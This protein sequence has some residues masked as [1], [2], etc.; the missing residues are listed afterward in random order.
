V[1]SGRE[2]Y[3]G[4]WRRSGGHIGSVKVRCKSAWLLHFA[5]ALPIRWSWQLDN[6]TALIGCRGY[7][8]AGAGAVV[9][10][11]RWCWIVRPCAFGCA[12]MELVVFP[13]GPTPPPIRDRANQVSG[14]RGVRPVFAYVHHPALLQEWLPCPAA[15][16]GLDTRRRRTTTARRRDDG[17]PR[18][19]PRSLVIHAR[20]CWPDRGT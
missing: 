10:G 18:T 4:R 16:D 8:A 15:T 12:H 17:S 13:A 7:H 6:S 1:A 20:C 5:A 19:F 14:R 11:A 3:G 2:V 9:P